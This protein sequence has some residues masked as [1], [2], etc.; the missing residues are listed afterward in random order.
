MN[1]FNKILSLIC[2]FFLVWSLWEYPYY[3][4]FFSAFLM[5]Y[6]SL[7]SRFPF[8]WLFCLPALLP[9]MDFSPVSG[10]F[11]YDEFDFLILVTLAV[12]LWFF[13]PDKI[14]SPVSPNVKTLFIIFW[15]SVFIST[16]IGLLPF[17][18]IDINAFN[19]YHSHYNSLRI[20]KGFLW[21]FLLQ[22]FFKQDL[23]FIENYKL[24]FIPGMLTGLTG[25]ALYVLWERQV[26]SGII[27]FD[28]A[29]RIVG[30]FSGMHIGGACVDAYFAGM[31]P[32][33]AA[34]FFKKDKLTRLFGI[35][36]FLAGSY[37]LL[38][39]FSRIVYL[40]VFVAGIVL[41]ISLFINSFSKRQIFILGAAFTLLFSIVLIPILNGQFIKSRFS[42]TFRDIGARINHWQ[43]SFNMMD[44]DLLTWLFGT[45][46]GS[47]PR[48]Y[49]QKSTE[50][51]KPSFY[52]YIEEDRNIFLKL[53]PGGFLYMGQKI[54]IS[55]YSSYL[56]KFKARSTVKDFTVTIC[57][58]SLLHSFRFVWLR[59]KNDARNEWVQYEIPFESGELGKGRP[60]Y[61]RR[62]VY[63]AFF[64]GDPQAD[65]DIDNISVVDD[66]G[67]ELVQNG[68]FSNGNDYWFFTADNH[69]PWHMKNFWC[70]ILFEQGALGLLFFM[71]FTCI[72][73]T[74][75]VQNIFIGDFYSI[76]IL[77]SM[78][79]FFTVGLVD[80]LFDFP[81][82][83]LFFFMLSYSVFFQ[84]NPL[85]INVSG[86][87]AAAEI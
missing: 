15:I 73:V 81:R 5:A 64:N 17:Q 10:W 80:S 75:A 68:D 32:F 22:P 87:N 69:L 4:I 78:A 58:K 45:G 24:Y 16:I 14:K 18:K 7:V 48:I 40:A 28:S 79:G 55:A 27:N 62:P 12:K 36:L 71:G 6:A 1:P 63:I 20:A 67:R 84:P 23:R 76:I 44:D 21:A 13:K 52:S 77:S 61:Q 41:M 30:P 72:V 59:H 70:H 34:C 86:N 53:S 37:A 65:I 60:L 35:L 8:I 49:A 38:V 47:Y 43:N 31:L 46:I 33:A 19:N 54:P 26:F 56:L 2:T 50:G 57:E 39:T 42:H 83:I 3:P 29:F 85:K 9:V 74:K 11:F 82:L 66:K 51:E 25:A